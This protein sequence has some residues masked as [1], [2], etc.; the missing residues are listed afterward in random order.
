MKRIHVFLFSFIVLVAIF[1]RFAKLGVYPMG[2]SWDEA[3]IGYNGYG[4]ATV[5]RDE[6]LSKMPVTFKSF[7]DYKAAVAIYANAV[8]TILLG[9]TPFAIRFPMALAGVISVIS[10]YFISKYFFKREETALFSM[11][12]FAVSPLN[13]HYSRIAFESGIAVSLVTFGILTFLYAKKHGW[14]YILSSVTFALSMYAYHSSKFTAPL[15]VI[16]LLVMFFKERKKQLVFLCI[17]FVVGMC[18]LFPL[19]KETVSG[20]AGERFFMTSA[21]AD[22]HG[23]KPLPEVIKT[24][25]IQTIAHANPQFLLFGKTDTYRHGNGEFGVLSYVEGVFLFAS[26]VLFCLNKNVRRSY[27]WMIVGILIGILPAAISVGVPHSNRAHGILPWTILFASVSFDFLWQHIPE[28]K[29]KLSVLILGMFLFLQTVLYIRMYLSVYGQNTKALQDFQY[30]YEQAIAI[31]R[32]NE[33]DVDRVIM[34]DR[35]GQAYIYVILFKKLTPIEWQQGALANYTFRH[36]EWD[37]D[38]ELKRTLLI[39]TGDEIPKDAK[40]LINEILYP[41]GSVDLRIVKL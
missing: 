33:P 26:I 2:L 36:I 13:I 8:S 41:D 28:K 21:I 29:K 20:N 35:L 16:L 19:I 39:G 10:V 27:W 40:G 9:V 11:A 37:N 5:H 3:A 17:S 1:L 34:T 31:S 24:V 12:L 14:L 38:K 18:M 30:G 15:I 7:G 6:W 23:L 22:R 4:I 32:A 25:T